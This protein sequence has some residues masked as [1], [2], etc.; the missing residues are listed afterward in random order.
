MNG[1]SLGMQTLFLDKNLHMVFLNCKILELFLDKKCQCLSPQQLGCMNL[2]FQWLLSI[3]SMLLK[4]S[5]HLV[6]YS[7]DILCHLKASILIF[8]NKVGRA[9]RNPIFITLVIKHSRPGLLMCMPIIWSFWF[10]VKFKCLF[11]HGL[12]SVS[13]IRSVRCPL[14][15]SGFALNFLASIHQNLSSSAAEK[16]TCCQTFILK[17]VPPVMFSQM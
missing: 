6:D 11:Y 5:D 1:N 14:C 16:N 17:I 4:M 8:L 13:V 9:G 12:I 10:S 7:L 2:S 15:T 3:T